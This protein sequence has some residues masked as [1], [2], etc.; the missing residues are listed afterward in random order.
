MAVRLLALHRGRALLPTNIFISVSDSNLCQRLNKTQLLVILEG[1]GKLI[2]IVHLIGSRTRYLPACSV[3]T[4]TLSH[5][6][7][8]VD[9][10]NRLWKVKDVEHIYDINIYKEKPHSTLFL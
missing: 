3:L 9:K 1:L 8:L 5:A 2:K 6:H 7:S 4:T 10:T